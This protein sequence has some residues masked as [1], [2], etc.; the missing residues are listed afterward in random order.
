[1]AACTCNA[2]FVGLTCQLVCPINTQEEG[3]QC[4]Q[5]PQFFTKREGA[6]SCVLN[7]Q[8]FFTDFVLPTPSADVTLLLAG[9]RTLIEALRPGIYS[10]RDFAFT[11]TD[12]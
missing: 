11:E 10:D 7:P 12:D 1:M 8:Q 9:V 3:G 4:A 6:G 2:G 5:C